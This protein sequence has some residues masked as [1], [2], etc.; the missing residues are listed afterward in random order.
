MLLILSPDK[1]YNCLQQSC[2]EEQMLLPLGDAILPRS[3]SREYIL[4]EEENFKWDVIIFEDKK[5]QIRRE[6]RNPCE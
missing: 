4:N 6:V 1:F 3:N 2:N 5:V